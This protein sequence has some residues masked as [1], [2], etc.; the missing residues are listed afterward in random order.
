MP[1]GM[2]QDTAARFNCSTRLIQKFW[3]VLK[4][5]TEN[6]QQMFEKALDVIQALPV[7]ERTTVTFPNLLFKT[8][9]ELEILNVTQTA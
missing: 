4:Q 5:H 2:I 9:S 6:Q 1:P 7:K 3:K 8:V